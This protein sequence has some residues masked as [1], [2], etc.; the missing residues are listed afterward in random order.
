VDLVPPTV[1]I[2]NP[3]NASVIS[4]AATLTASA[5]DNIAVAGVTFYIDG[6]KQGSEITSA[7]YTESWDSTAATKGVHSIFAV[8]RD[9]SNNYATSTAVSVDVENAPPVIS[10]ISANPSDT[11]AVITWTTDR[12]ATSSILYGTSQS[13]DLS[14]TS[15]SFDTSHSIMLTGLSDQ[16]QFHFEITAGDALGYYATSSDQVFT[17]NVTASSGSSGSGSSG[18]SFSP[19]GPAMASTPVLTLPATPPVS[20]FFTATLSYGTQSASVTRLQQL[21]ATNPTLYPSG[22]VTGYYGVLTRAAIEAL[23][24]TE[25]IATP[26]SADYGI[27]DAK[28]Q[29]ALAA[30]L[31]S[32]TNAP[33][34]STAT[35]ASASG[36]TTSG[37]ATSP[38]AA[39]APIE[40]SLSYGISGPDVEELQILLNRYPF[41]QVAV[42]GVGSPGNETQYFG[43]ATLAA[44]ERFQ[45]LW[46]IAAPGSAGYGIVGPLTRAKLAQLYPGS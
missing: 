1:S 34:A 4:G 46:K 40:Q 6:T 33:T 23:Q 24:I 32:A 45:T 19:S 15:G 7:P 14:A 28:T 30:L 22:L 31:S 44:V 17:T 10:A 8:A 13:Y 18:S 12:A 39:P 5:S 16:T 26:A 20:T 43:P 36:A 41:T 29:S 3:T 9:T 37:F 27:F 21:L 35:P 2:S 42:L 11:S 25:H 38:S